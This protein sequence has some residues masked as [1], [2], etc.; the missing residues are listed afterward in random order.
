MNE[1]DA[2]PTTSSAFDIGAVQTRSVWWRGRV[3]PVGELLGELQ[4]MGFP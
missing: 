1:N 3:Q 4:A 2:A